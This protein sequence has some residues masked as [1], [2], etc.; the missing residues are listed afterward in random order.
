VQVAGTNLMARRTEDESEEKWVLLL[1]TAV[2][3][4][5]LYVIAATVGALIGG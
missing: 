5:I 1:I 3:I 4:F 2:M